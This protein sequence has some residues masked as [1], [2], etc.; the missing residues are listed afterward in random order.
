MRKISKVNKE[1]GPTLAI[2]PTAGISKEAKKRADEKERNTRSN[3]LAEKLRS[4]IET[5][6]SEDAKILNYPK[7]IS[8]SNTFNYSF[9]PKLCV[10][11]NGQILW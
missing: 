3:E 9:T 10:T 7:R 1:W 5:T 4:Q 2:A 6:G 8:T 11:L